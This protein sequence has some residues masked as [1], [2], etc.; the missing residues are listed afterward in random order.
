MEIKKSKYE[1]Y[2]WYSDKQ[3]PELISKEE[4]FELQIDNNKNPF[5]V[6][7]YLV[8]D[9]RSISIKYVDG[10]YHVNETSLDKIDKSDERVYIG[11]KMD[12]RRLRFAQQW[13]ETNDPLCEGLKIQTPGQLIFLGFKK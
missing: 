10:E 2:I 3:S 5:I 9:E 13:D 11:N 4:D 1:G 8:D 12:G 6:E 7:G